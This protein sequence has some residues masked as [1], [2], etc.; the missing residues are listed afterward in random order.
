MDWRKEEETP[1][2]WPA[3]ADVFIGFL[4]LVLIAGLTAYTVATGKGQEPPPAKQEFRKIFEELFAH[5][6]SFA[7][8]DESE[9]PRV[10]NQGFS[11]LNIYFPAAFLFE[12]CGTELMRPAVV[13]LNDLKELFKRFDEQILRV[14]I[15]GHTDTDRPHPGGQCYKTGIYTNWELSARR[16]ITVLELLAPDDGSGLDPHKIWAAA[17][18]EYHPVINRSD[19]EA[20][21]R[22]RRIEVLVRFKELGR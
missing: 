10:D 5:S 9:Q 20:K 12:P 17:L 19:V 16:A 13:E 2:Y 3:V 11:E 22:N 15:T 8:V 21:S 6:S 4:A 1:N 18:G 14:Q 7:R